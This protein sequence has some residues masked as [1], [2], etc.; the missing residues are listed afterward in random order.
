[1]V[2]YRYLIAAMITVLA[3]RDNSYSYIYF[4]FNN[5]DNITTGTLSTARLNTSSVTLKGSMTNGAEFIRIGSATVYGTITSTGGFKGDGSGLYNISTTLSPGNSTYADL[6]SSPTW[7]GTHTFG[8]NSSL[9]GIRATISGGINNT[10]SGDESTIS[11]GQGNTASGNFTIIGGGVDNRALGTEATV[12]GGNTNA[13]SGADATVSGGQNN[14]ATGDYGVVPGGFDNTASGNYSFA[15]GK[16]ASSTANGAFTWSDSQGNAPAN[17]VTDQTRFKSQGGVWFS[18][19]PNYHSPGLFMDSSNRVGIGTNTPSSKLDIVNGSITVR[20]TNMGISVDGEVRGATITV[21]S[22]MTILC[23]QNN[24]L[25]IIR[26]SAG[27]GS[28]AFRGQSKSWVFGVQ[29]DGDVFFY[30]NTNFATRFVIDTND[31]NIGIGTEDASSL[32]YVSGGSITT[33]GANAGVIIGSNPVMVSAEVMSEGALIGNSTS[34]NFTG[35]VTVTQTGRQTTVNVPVPAASV[36]I[37]TKTFDMRIPGDVFAATATFLAIEGVSFATGRST[38][39]IQNMTAYCLR[40]STTSDVKFSVQMATANTIAKWESLYTSSWTLTQS[41]IGYGNSAYLTA[42][43][44][45]TTINAGQTL[46]LWVH[47]APSSGTCSECGMKM[48]YWEKT[49]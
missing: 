32:L 47:Q 6:S 48:R 9:T 20:G 16:S 11:G 30:D 7:T 3:F 8:R 36:E 39:V 29:D 42:I 18:T 25:S 31:G 17:G 37:S 15:G 27:E 1:M 2:K 38:I 12:G 35:E 41:A 5:A 10:A 46:A 45:S 22:S 44:S 49:P 26:N 13:A 40:A 21:L 43:P 28:I 23:N 14:F 24:C 33:R 19:S 34:F 4:L